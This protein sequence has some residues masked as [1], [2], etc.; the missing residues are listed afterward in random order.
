MLL[1][2]LNYQNLAIAVPPSS[3]PSPSGLTS[4]ATF[5]LGFELNV[6]VYPFSKMSHPY[7][8]G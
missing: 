3:P 2:I 1:Y 4:G 5:H 8:L 7:S 6:I